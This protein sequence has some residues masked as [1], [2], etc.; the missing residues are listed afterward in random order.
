LEVEGRVAWLHKWARAIMPHFPFPMPAVTT[1]VPIIESLRELNLAGA[2]LL[3]L[4][5]ETRKAGCPAWGDGAFPPPPAV[6][7]GRRASGGGEPGAPWEAVLLDFLTF[8]LVRGQTVPAEGLSALES[9]E[10]VGVLTAEVAAELLELIERSLP[11]ASPERRMGLL[12]AVTDLAGR[13]DP[14]SGARLLC[15]ATQHRLSAAQAG[16]PLKAI[17][18]WDLAGSWLQSVP[19]LLWQLGAAQP[20][21]TALALR[22]MLDCA[23]L[24]PVGSPVSD[25]LVQL[26][27]TLQPFFCAAVAK[28]GAKR[29]LSADTGERAV[30]GRAELGFRFRV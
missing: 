2:A 6:K 24:A 20:A 25:L 8:A 27:P 3:Q 12:A 14:R 15:L 11:L 23:R 26:Q 10:P 1:T 4:A 17:V 9:E 18:P 30:Y 13:S 21:T 22:M 28:K 19:R 29:A 7:E 5:V 16:A